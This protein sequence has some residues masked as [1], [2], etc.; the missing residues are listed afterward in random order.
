MN[1]YT[2]VDARKSTGRDTI[3]ISGQRVGMAF[4]ASRDL[5]FTHVLRRR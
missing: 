3:A 2:A 1:T 5:G 4:L